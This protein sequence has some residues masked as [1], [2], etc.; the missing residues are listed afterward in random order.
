[1]S[2]DRRVVLHFDTKG[3]TSSL[4]EARFVPQRYEPNYAYPL[5]VLLHGRGGDEQQMLRS[6]PALSWRNYVALGL[7][8][9]EV[10]AR[11]DNEVGFGWGPDFARAER[12]PA[13][14][15]TK[16]SDAEIF[17]RT[18]N[19]TTPDA[20]D[21]LEQSIFSAVRQVRRSLHV[22]SERIFLVGCGEGAAVAYRLGL[23]YPDRFAGVVA[24]NGWIP[25]GFR[26]L[27][28]VKDCRDLRIMVAHGQWNSRTPI[29][30]AQRDVATLRAAGLPIAF[31]AYPYANR[32]TSPMLA[33]VDTWLMTQCTG[34]QF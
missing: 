1:M 27:G 34:D 10:I 31:Q 20:I 26:P 29:E 33:D 15:A 32:V 14:P 28:R 12:R 3:T 19:G 13:W 4:V 11:R 5:L 21:L 7:R 24:L 25:G 8:G 6:M 23:S 18:M 17:R 2:G 22:H 16:E 30:R 9:P